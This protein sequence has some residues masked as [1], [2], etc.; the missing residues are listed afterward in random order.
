MA[1]GEAGQHGHGVEARE[2]DRAGSKRYA[3]PLQYPSVK[4][5]HEQGDRESEIMTLTPA[6]PPGTARSVKLLSSR[7]SALLQA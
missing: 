2:R 5:G 1:H 7:Q 3:G 4:R 6:T